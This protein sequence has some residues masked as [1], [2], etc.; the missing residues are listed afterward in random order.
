[1]EAEL[2]DSPRTRE[3]CEKVGVEWGELQETQGQF[4]RKLV[5]KQAPR[6][7]VQLYQDY[8]ERRRMR[9]VQLVLSARSLLHSPT[10]SSFRPSSA[11]PSSQTRFLL[12]EE[13]KKLSLLRKKQAHTVQSLLQRRQIQSEARE[14]FKLRDE[15]LKLKEEMWARQVEL[16][17]KEG[18]ERKRRDEERRLGEERELEL[19]G[20]EMQKERL[21]QELRKK[22]QDE[23]KEKQ[24][25]IAARMEAEEAQRRQASFHLR[26]E[27]IQAQIRAQLESRREDMQLRDSQ[28]IEALQTLKEQLHAKS[29][30]AHEAKEM[31]LA[32]ARRNLE[33]I[34]R[35]QVAKYAAKQAQTETRRQEFQQKREQKRLQLQAKAK[36]KQEAIARALAQGQSLTHQRQSS[37]LH[38][39]RKAAIR[40]KALEYTAEIDRSRRKHEETARDAARAA[41]KQRME[42]QERDRKLEI[43]KKLRQAEGKLA[44]GLAQ[45]AWELRIKKE[46]KRLLRLER[47][48]EVIR[49]ERVRIYQQKETEK[50]L[51]QADL[52]AKHV[53]EEREKLRLERERIKRE[54]EKEREILLLQGERPVTAPSPSLPQSPKAI[55]NDTDM[56]FWATT[57]RST[58]SHKSVS[59]PHRDLQELKQQKVRVLRAELELEQRR[60]DER[61]R[62]LA[63]AGDAGERQRL[64]GLFGVE[65]AQAVQRLEELTKRFD[66][67]IVRVRRSRL[68]R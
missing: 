63:Q 5:G 52:Q 6:E 20:R 15:K 47:A 24:R 2:S 18:E 34:K 33:D 51:K 32:T 8:Y 45:K 13:Q 7:I 39:M 38:S 64:E 11:A 9:K 57:T 40:L 26:L 23:L 36:A 66:E 10:A 67:D 21:A 19:K 27:A 48:E 56:L 54:M 22:A 30:A 42:S 14:K 28:R 55:S 44:A 53:Q 46:Q 61:D 35:E 12:S 62:V 68:M 31:R 59:D 17:R 43:Q 58:L 4:V 49:V 3:A 25:K 50:R 60:E 37:Y 1:M 41:V 29:E 65:R 16:S